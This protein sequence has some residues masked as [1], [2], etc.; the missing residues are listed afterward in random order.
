MYPLSFYPLLCLGD[1]IVSTKDQWLRTIS[2]NKLCDYI[3]KELHQKHIQDKCTTFVEIKKIP[4]LENTCIRHLILY[5][6]IAVI[7]NTHSKAWL[8]L[9]NSTNVESKLR[10]EIS[11]MQNREGNSPCSSRKKNIIKFELY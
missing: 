4:I 6:P 7:I 5:K 9:S 11:Q 3:G 10:I 8:Q 2:F 1:Y